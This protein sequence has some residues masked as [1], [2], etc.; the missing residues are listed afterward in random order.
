MEHGPPVVD[1][2]WRDLL[3]EKPVLKPREGQ[4]LEE[5]QRDALLTHC[6]LSAGAKAV[7]EE[8]RLFFGLP[9]LRLVAQDGRWFV[10]VSKISARHGVTTWQD[11]A[12][13]RTPVEAFA[14]AKVA[15]ENY[16][17]GKQVREEM[18]R[19]QAEADQ[20]AEVVP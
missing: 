6:V 18:K 17:R 7:Q 4:A 2:A 10:L 14:M 20:P 11:I 3:G 19:K 5:A 8:A 13:G 15:A 1:R 12:N 9:D 16:Q